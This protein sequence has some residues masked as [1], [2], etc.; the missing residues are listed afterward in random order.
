MG[1]WEVL[2][3]II[4]RQLVVLMSSVEFEVLYMGLLISLVFLSFYAGL[5]FSLMY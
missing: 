3:T 1:P 5:Q 2:G 4:A